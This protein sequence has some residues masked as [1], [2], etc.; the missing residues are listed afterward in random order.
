MIVV[1]DVVYVEPPTLNSTISFETSFE[2]IFLFQ[3]VDLSVIDIN[4]I[5]INLVLC[6]NF[7]NI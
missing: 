6:C 5:F 4:C 3:L 1:L 7:Y 2:R